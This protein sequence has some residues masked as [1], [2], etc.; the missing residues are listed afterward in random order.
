MFYHALTGNGGATPTEPVSTQMMITA[1]SNLGTENYG[2][3]AIENCKFNKLKII[4]YGNI[5]NAFD[6]YPKITVGET[7]YNRPSTE[8][9]IDVLNKKLEIDVVSIKSNYESTNIVVELF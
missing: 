7:I 5:E 9:I 6:N 1:S 4:S 8:T 2:R 3:L